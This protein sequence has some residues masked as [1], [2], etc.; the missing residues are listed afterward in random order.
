MSDNFFR[1]MM[2]LSLTNVFLVLRLSH[3]Y[4]I[5]LYLATVEQHQT[6]PSSK[7]HKQV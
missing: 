5:H 7:M 6:D 4:E 1:F 3:L 2:C